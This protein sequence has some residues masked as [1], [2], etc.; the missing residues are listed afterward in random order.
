MVVLDEFTMRMSVGMLAAGFEAVKL[1]LVKFAV[2]KFASG[3]CVG[4]TP[5]IS[6]I[7]S[8]ESAS[9]PCD[10]PYATSWLKLW[11]DVSSLIDMLQVPGVEGEPG[12]T[13]EIAAVM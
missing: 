12:E 9:C 5:V 7:H 3:G 2:P 6:S 1:R 10:P 11:W 4:E 8:A 13:W